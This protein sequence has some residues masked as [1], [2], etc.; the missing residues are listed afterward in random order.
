MLMRRC[1][2]GNVRARPRADALGDLTPREFLLTQKPE[3]LLKGGPYYEALTVG[4]RSIRER[5]AVF[6]LTHALCKGQGYRRTAAMFVL[7]IRLPFTVLT[8]VARKEPS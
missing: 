6:P 7:E 8:P 2:G 1:T 4:L 3:S 5:T